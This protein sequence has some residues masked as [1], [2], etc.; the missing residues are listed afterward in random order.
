[1][2]LNTV[3]TDKDVKGLRILVDKIDTNVRSLKTLGY[4]LK[5]YGPFLNPMVM[6]KLPDEVRLAVTK[7]IKNEEWELG[8]I[9][10]IIKADLTAREQCAHLNA[11]GNYTVQS[12][13][14]RNAFPT[15]AALLNNENRVTCSFCKNHHLSA[16]CTVVT[17]P[18]QRKQILLKQGQCFVCL[19]KG[20]RSRECKSNVYCFICKQRHHQAICDS[21]RPTLGE[22]RSPMRNT[23]NVTQQVQRN[24]NQNSPTVNQAN[25]P[26]PRSIGTPPVTQT[27][28]MHVQSRTS[29]LLQTARGY[30]SSPTNPNSEKISR[31]IFDTGSKHSYISANL[32]DALQLPTVSQET[33]EV[34]VF[35][36]AAGTIQTC[37]IVQFCVRSSYNGLCVYVTAYVVPILCA[38]LSEQAI[39]FAASS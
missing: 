21:A 22:A 12:R 27:M 24:L 20:H 18:A 2:N 36:S 14:N 8:R 13:P 26:S 15:T 3:S 29:I 4:D 38:P 16:K 5:E 35:G 37:D 30:I 39:K 34:K 11:K 23:P 1:M 6:S 7:Q 32:R 33:I 10:E 9:L 31:L 25:Q 17:D 28:T 19:K